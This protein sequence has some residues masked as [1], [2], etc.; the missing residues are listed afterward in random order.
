MAD[1][2]NINEK[3][4][5]AG[6]W[7][8]EVEKDKITID[9]SL[10]TMLGY[11]AGD[12]NN[13]LQTW[14]QLI[15]P[16]YI[17]ALCQIYKDHVASKGTKPFVLEL[18]LTNKNS[19]TTYILVTG[20]VIKWTEH[21]EP[22]TMWGS[23]MDVSPFKDAEK[24][25]QQVKDL[26]TKTNQIASVGGWELNLETN[27]VLWTPVTKSIFEIPEDFVPNLDSSDQF[28]KTGKYRAKIKRAVDRAITKGIPFDIELKIITAKGKEK[29]TRSVG[30]AEFVDGK[31]TR[32]YGV[33]Q[34]IN[35][36]KLHEE[37][38]QQKN[39]Q[40]Q[41]AVSEKLDFLSIMS[42]EIR[43]PMNAVIG[44]TNLL[45]QNP[46]ADQV[47]YLNVLK[48]SAENL[49]VLINDI[50][51]YNKINA[52]K[53]ELEN[54]AFDLRELCTNIKSA[55][56][57]EADKKDLILNINIDSKIPASIKGDPMR[58]GQIITNLIANAIKFTPAGKV[59]VSIKVVKQTTH[60]V[61][62]YFEVT[63]TGIGIPKDKLDYIFEK[64]S[65]ATSETTRK[66]GGTG[67][68]LAIIKRLLE[69]VGSKINVTSVP[70]QGSSF[71]FK[72][73]FKKSAVK[74]QE[75]EPT[76]VPTGKELTGKK[77]LIVEDN[78]I[79]VLV[80]KKFLQQWGMEFDVAQNGLIAVEKASNNFFDLI[81][82]DL[83]M[84]EMD[85]FDAT[86]AI[87]KLSAMHQHLP[88]LALTASVVA[89]MKEKVLEAGMNECINKPFKPADLYATLHH[90]LIGNVVEMHI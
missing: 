81:L 22:E 74:L 34:D 57:Q 12:I 55:Q 25:L 28:F 60:N 71:F 63:D 19:T 78:P 89:D 38:L 27:K 15:K 7:E 3:E 30:Q 88:I 41:K 50:L 73:K 14:R 23:Y 16:D 51:D 5:R 47:E 32:L 85:G 35:Q 84:P 11:N 46:R 49:L 80:I 82:M 26:L 13:N 8:W 6:Y 21:H 83:Q 69:M 48:Y 72:L 17:D 36:R 66:Y 70:G 43:T 59:D 77:I 31:C 62:L 65:Q 67:L 10:Q 4:I 86:I 39:E 53:I 37:A 44:F 2:V 68:G 75:L 61:T 9:S 56:Q 33:F 87:R 24:E 42:H 64:F 90:Y 58:L 52:G 40:L 76:D 45:L 20:K 18:G 54:I 29:W 79:N 1:T